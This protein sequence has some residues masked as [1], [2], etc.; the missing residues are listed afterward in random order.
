MAHNYSIVRCINF[1][2]TMYDFTSCE[3]KRP[4]HFEPLS[5]WKFLRKVDVST[6]WSRRPSQTGR[7][8]RV[9][10]YERVNTHT[11]THTHAQPH[12]HTHMPTLLVC[13]P[14][15]YHCC[16]VRGTRRLSR[17]TRSAGG[18]VDRVAK[19]WL[20]PGSKK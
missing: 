13:L 12:T 7:Q 11:I 19:L 18:K 10:V 17:Q 6:E 1:G 4:S 8:D 5:H 2:W 16:L 9:R 3:S 20:Q 14:E 15:S